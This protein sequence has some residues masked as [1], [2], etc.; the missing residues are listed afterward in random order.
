MEEGDD[1]GDGAAGEE[2]GP[3]P[4]QSVNEARASDAVF[5]ELEGRLEKWLSAHVNGQ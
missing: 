5:G 1:G 2:V 4:A 3:L